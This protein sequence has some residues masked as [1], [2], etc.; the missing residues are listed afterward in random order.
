M[1]PYGVYTP[2]LHLLVHALMRAHHH[3]NPR[4]YATWLDERFNKLLKAA[5]KDTSQ[6]TFENSVLLRM[7]RLLRP[8][9]SLKRGR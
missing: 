2:K 5:C 3:G 4:F 1:Q 8:D 9:A 6:L 7:Q